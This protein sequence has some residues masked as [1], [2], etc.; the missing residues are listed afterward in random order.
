MTAL[1]YSRLV[2]E[3]DSN[4]RASPQTKTYGPTT[5]TA[6]TFGWRGESILRDGFLF[7]CSVVVGVI[8]LLFEITGRV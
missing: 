6:G 7:I 2:V 3:S 5:R 1:T 4:T 8:N